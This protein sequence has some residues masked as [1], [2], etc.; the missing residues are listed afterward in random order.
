MIAIV[1]ETI[2]V[3]FSMLI[4]CVCFFL[5]AKYFGKILI[6]LFLH[7]I[8]WKLDRDLSHVFKEAFL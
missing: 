6:A 1:H 5:V 4:V 2:P 7:L 8:T 3:F